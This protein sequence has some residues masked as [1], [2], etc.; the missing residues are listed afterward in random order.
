M[1]F[2]PARTTLAFLSLAAFF[3]VATPGIGVA[4]AA[5]ESPKPA[6][7]AAPVQ[8]WLHVRGPHQN[9]TS[10]ETGLPDKITLDAAPNG[11]F[12]WSYDLSSRGTPVVA[13]DR[14]YVWGYR[15]E[16]DD[17]R[18]VL[19]CLDAN[20]GKLHW[21]YVSSDYLSDVVYNRYAIG[22]PSVD[23]QTG[24]VYMTTANGT[25]RGFSPD[26][27]LLWQV[28]MLEMFGRLSFPNARVG[29]PIVDDDLVILHFITTNW[30]A[31]GPPADRFYAFDKL[32]GEL[33]WSS[34][35]GTSPPKDSSMS[36][37]I[38]VW[39][40]GKRVLYAGTGCGHVVSLNAR[41]G[42][43][44]W[45]Y[46]MSLGG[47]NVGVLI[48][49]DDKI[50]AL[51]EDENLDSSKKGR[52]LAVTIDPPASATQ[53]ASTQPGVPGPAVYQKSAEL[54][55]NDLSVLSS[56]PVLAGDTVYLT[57]RSGDLCAIDANNGKVLWEKKVEPE[58]LHAS[59]VW[60]DGKIYAP[61][62]T[63]HF[64]VFR[65]DAKGATELSRVKLDGE[66]LGAPAI[67]NGKIFVHTTKKLYAF[68]KKTQP[69]SSPK[70][71]A[72]KAEEA[73]KAGPVTQIQ[74]VPNEL[75]LR[76]GDK[77]TF[78]V[79]GLDANGL[80]VKEI[81]I[82]TVTLKKFIP[83][84][85]LVKSEVDGAFEGQTFVVPK[86]AKISA[87]AFMATVDGMNGTFRG[88]VV[89]DLPY[90]ED[91]SKFQITEK[92]ATEEGAMFAYP[93]LP[94][95]G[96]RFRW[97]VRNVDGRNVLTKTIDN[98]SL[99]RA[100]TFIGHPDMSNYTLEAEVMTDGN[101]RNKSNVG[102]INQRYLILLDGNAKRL[103]VSSNAERLKVGVPFEIAASTWYCMKTRVDLDAKGDGIVRAKVW[104]KGDAEPEAWT[105][106]VPHKDA[107]KNGSP[108]VYGFA[109][110]N[111]FR[112]YV[113]NI[114]VTPNAKN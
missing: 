70:L 57:T 72:V 39:H 1:S 107:H 66:C 44:L 21:E 30:G 43:P 52:M 2:G 74:V 88:R 46:P 67:W 35:P 97:E 28:P 8:G 32:T 6:S 12:L 54:W 78:R 102:L 104:K 93:P 7:A 106:E 38:V 29:G 34:T 37:P 55:R 111:M 40:K 95:I 25:L 9:G 105:I 76:P 98:V 41:T 83:P 80:F 47:V 68:G 24:N 19:A 75:L 73:P 82:N 31:H 56:S 33:V 113:A 94:W 10:D 53:P 18:E 16:K 42:E 14:V 64:Y 101:K 50:I 15:G 71:S 108:G 86:D 4:R 3:L 51:H 85:A 79:R 5:D 58:Q 91:F 49:K 11:P 81:P 69:G 13:G 23:P 26:G 65:P 87:G 112:V 103:E 92:H 20:T 90:A 89:P 96:G 45:R 27:K 100:T 77:A 59:I 99:Q 114:R 84:T 36:T 22:A 61:L 109:L 62:Y 110:Q 63:G 17:L 60:A 48:H